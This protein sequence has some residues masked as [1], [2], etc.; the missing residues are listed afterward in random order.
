M[1][2]YITVLIMTISFFSFSQERKAKIYFINGITQD[3]FASIS[4][5]KIRFRVDQDSKKKKY[6]QD[7]VSHIRIKEGK[8]KGT[9]YYKTILGR[10]KVILVKIVYDGKVNLFNEYRDVYNPGTNGA[11]GTSQTIDKYFINKSLQDPFIR[12]LGKGNVTKKKFKEIAPNYFGDCPM[13]MQK[14][15]ENF[16]GKNKIKNV[17]KMYNTQCN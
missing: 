10:K 1:K 16:F 8:N 9:Y 17:V 5:F 13:L 7:E 3:G 12:D 11:A 14:I 15:E 6:D 4:K 2:I